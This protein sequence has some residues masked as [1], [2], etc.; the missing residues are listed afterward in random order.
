MFKKVVLSTLLFALI[1]VL[2]AGAII[3]TVDKAGNVAEARGGG[4][5]R[6]GEESA[7]FS[8]QRLGRGYG[9][10]NVDAGAQSEGRGGYGRGGAEAIDAER[11]YP[12]YE[13]P[14]EEWTEYGG[15]VVQAPGD[16]VD[17]V[18]ASGGGE[19]LVVG[20]GPSYM[21]SQGFVL[22]AGDAIMVRGYWEDSEFKAAQV[23][24]L[25]DGRVIA[26]RD[27]MGR[28]AWAGAG[29]RSQTS[30]LNGSGGREYASAAGSSSASG[31]AAVDEWLTLT[32]PV[33]S[34]DS[35]A[36]IVLTDDGQEITVENRPWWF[37]Q[38][39]GFATEAGNE[40][41]LVGFYEG[42]EFETGQIIDKTSGKAVLIREE[43]GRPLWAGRGR[44]G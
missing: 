6:S 32:G 31:Q 39:Q 11:R 21:E 7:D 5:G 8:T 43:S 41:T 27:E 19:E 17:L 1:G 20:T 23:T 4:R 30:V 15:V 35:N 40:V 29:R 24:R 44:R 36:L 14:P 9:A 12:N 38:D 22:E 33:V 42:E 2:V 25:R 3:R 28:P 37:A 13:A 26:L 18:I 10:S 16:G 34:A